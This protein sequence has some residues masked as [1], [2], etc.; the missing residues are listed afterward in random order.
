MFLPE[1]TLI[2]DYQYHIQQ[3]ILTIDYKRLINGL[4]VTR[5]AF[6]LQTNK[7]TRRKKNGKHFIS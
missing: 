1:S 7:S 3:Q 2:I 4:F 6:L 5:L